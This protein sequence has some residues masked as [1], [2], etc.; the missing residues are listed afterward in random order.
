MRPDQRSGQGQRAERI[1]D[2]ELLEMTDE[3]MCLSMHQPWAT[4]LVTGI[5]V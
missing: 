2:R 4:L 1:Q 5:K 3:G